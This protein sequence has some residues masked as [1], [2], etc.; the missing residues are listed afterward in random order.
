M[1]ATRG[2]IRGMHPAAGTLADALAAEF[3]ILEVMKRR[4]VF[5]RRGRPVQGSRWLLLGFRPGPLLAGLTSRLDGLRAN[6]AV[7]DEFDPDHPWTPWGD[8]VEV[9]VMGERGTTTQ[10]LFDR[11]PPASVLVVIGGV[12]ETLSYDVSYQERSSTDVVV[13]P[14]ASGGRWRIAR[15]CASEPI[16]MN[17]PVQ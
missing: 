8:S 17:F 4:G 12:L 3:V 11:A 7:V 14:H 15:P 13:V 10:H 5:D 1:Q 16:R 6:T 9:I 2:I